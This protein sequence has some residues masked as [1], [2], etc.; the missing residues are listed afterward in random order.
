MKSIKCPEGGREGGRVV[1]LRR[2]EPEGLGFRPRPPPSQGTGVERP[3]LVTVKLLKDLF[4]FGV[5]GNP[6][7]LEEK[8]FF[9][10]TFKV[11]L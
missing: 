9:F 2:G 7:R 5:K 6:C 11:V 4:P 3:R 8:G 1:G 10:S